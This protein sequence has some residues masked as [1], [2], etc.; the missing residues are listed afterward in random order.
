M[1]RLAVAGPLIGT[2]VTDLSIKSPTDPGAAAVAPLDGVGSGMDLLAVWAAPYTEPPARTAARSQARSIRQEEGFYGPESGVSMLTGDDLRSKLEAGPVA[3]GPMLV[4]FFSPRCPHCIA[5]RTSFVS[6]ASQVASLGVFSYAVDCTASS[7]TCTAHKVSG[8]P[9]VALFVADE[10]TPGGWKQVS[11]EGPRSVDGIVSWVRTLAGAPPN[12]P[13]DPSAISAGEG[14]DAS[15]ASDCAAHE[16]PPDRDPADS[17][18]VSAPSASPVSASGT[19]NE[20]M[21][22]HPEGPIEGES[23]GEIGEGD[24]EIDGE[25]G[26]ERVEDDAVVATA[27]SWAL[28]RDGHWQVMQSWVPGTESSQLEGGRLRATG[29]VLCGSS[30]TARPFATLMYSLEADT[31]SGRRVVAWAMQVYDPKEKVSRGYRGKR[32]DRE[33]GEIRESRGQVRR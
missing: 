11:H 16:H 27:L 26:G 18:S 5:F 15:G 4:E 22:G 3:A 9:T 30:G 13:S 1:R 31:A 23:G 14:C 17:A 8:V 2:H 6:I 32:N 20:E 19:A 29:P 21:P 10:S 12:A 33:I 28:Y 25:T 24:L 7:A